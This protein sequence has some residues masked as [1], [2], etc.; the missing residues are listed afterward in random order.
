MKLQGLAAAILFR[1]VLGWQRWLCPPCRCFTAT[2][3]SGW[4][5][6]WVCWRSC[7]VSATCGRL[8]RC[9]PC[10]G[11]TRHL[12]QSRRSSLGISH[13][14]AAAGGPLRLQIFRSCPVHRRL[15]PA[16][17]ERMGGQAYS[18]DPLREQWRSWRV[19][20]LCAAVMFAVVVGLSFYLAPFAGVLRMVETRIVGWSRRS[21]LHRRAA[22]H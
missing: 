22:C 5:G 6:R 10:R 1:R 7:Q 2:V 18:A 21:D 16:Y 9:L 15:R 3:G 8:T 20:A 11:T 13:S 4:A 17:P 19:P 12:G 14:A